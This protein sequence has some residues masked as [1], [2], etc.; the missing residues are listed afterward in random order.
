MVP[1]LPHPC[2]TLFLMGP[3]TQIKRMM[4][5]HRIFATI[6]YLGAIIAT[7]VVAFKVRCFRFV[8]PAVKAVSRHGN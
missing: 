1:L 6:A 7:L 8:Q 3:V 5:Q 2:S 4:D